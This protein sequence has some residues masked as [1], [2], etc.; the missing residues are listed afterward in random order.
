[1]QNMRRKIAVRFKN[2]ASNRKDSILVIYFLTKAKRACES[3]YIHENTAVFLFREIKNGSVVAT[4]KARLI[5]SLKVADRHEETIT[6]YVK[7]GS[8]FLRLQATEG[9]AANNED[10]G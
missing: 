6:T 1:M 3:S 9:K 10:I 7:A 2:Q 8:T 5:L 4:I